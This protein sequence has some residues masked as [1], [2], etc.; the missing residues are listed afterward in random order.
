VVE[1]R[2]DRGL[3]GERQGQLACRVVDDLS[4]AQLERDLLDEERVASRA[5][6]DRPHERLGQA[7]TR[8][9][10]GDL[11]DLAQAEPAELDALDL[12]AGE[13]GRTHVEELG[14]RAAQDEH[15]GVALRGQEL[16]QQVQ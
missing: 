4:V 11:R 9:A 16:V 1:T 15:G 13:G 2:L 7:P 12:D 14:A 8:G 3:D 5:F 6:H 10:R